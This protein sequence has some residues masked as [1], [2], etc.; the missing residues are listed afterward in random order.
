MD[1]SQFL[2]DLG[3]EVAKDQLN[4]ALKDP[5]SIPGLGNNP[6]VA[7]GLKLL[8]VARQTGKSPEE[9]LQLLQD[10]QA[11]Y[12]QAGTMYC[13]TQKPELY[14]YTAA[15]AGGIGVVATL[16]LVMIVKL[17]SRKKAA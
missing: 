11:L 10:P 5:S 14:Q 4:N 7:L 8:E 1:F 12:E 13:I 9:L 3:K 17:F 6:N 16:L 15:A 2:R